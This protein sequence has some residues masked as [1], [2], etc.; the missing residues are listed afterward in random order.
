[1]YHSF[2][3]KTLGAVEEL[4]PGFRAIWPQIKAACGV[5]NRC[6]R[7]VSFTDSV[8]PVIL[9]DT[10]SAERFALDLRD[11]SLSAS[12]HVSGGEWAMHAGSNHD[13]AIAEVPSTHAV[14]TCVYNRYHRTFSMTVQV[15]KLPAQI[16][17][18]V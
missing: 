5:S 9:D 13:Q 18:R 4:L 2:Q 17:A 1:M 8:E 15:A 16:A 10:D 14:V 11:M 12:R 3:T 7:S 6:P